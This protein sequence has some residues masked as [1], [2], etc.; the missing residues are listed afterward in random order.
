MRTVYNVGGLEM[1]QLL[2]EALRRLRELERTGR[3]RWHL[4][5]REHGGGDTDVQ[6]R[7]Q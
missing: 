6:S 3:Y 5:R 2:C 1:V 4:K 7:S